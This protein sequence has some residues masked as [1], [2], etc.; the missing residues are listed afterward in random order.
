MKL[1][2]NALVKFIVGIVLISLLL[3]LPAG[4]LA[5]YNGILLCCLLFVPMLILGIVLFFKF[6]SLLEKRLDS[7]EK[8]NTQ[9]GVVAFSG[10]A[11]VASFL[12]AGFDFRF[13]WSEIPDFVVII[14]SVLFLFSYALYAE[15]MREN[16]YLS[17]NVNVQQNQKVIDTGLYSFVRHPMYLATVIMFLSMPLVL[18]SLYAF[19]IMLVYPAVIVVRIYNEEELL[20]NEL[21]GYREYKE[22]VKYRLIPFIF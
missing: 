22:K 18:G 13:G 2:V 6:P 4:T 9:K 8:D 14:A 21:S 5:F 11:F 19:L 10:L 16:E 12:V 20:T 3:F 7:K 17:R 1:L 15:V